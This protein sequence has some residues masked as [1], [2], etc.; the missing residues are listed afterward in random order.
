[1]HYSNSTGSPPPSPRQQKEECLDFQLECVCVQVRGRRRD[2]DINGENWEASQTLGFTIVAQRER[3]KGERERGEEE[4][5]VSPKVRAIQ[6]RE[7][8]KV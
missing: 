3:G 5:D 2:E 6:L 8:L 1:M 4:T 7:E